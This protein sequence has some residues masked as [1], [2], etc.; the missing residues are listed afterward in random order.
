VSGSPGYVFSAESRALFR[1]AVRADDATWARARGWALT[2]GLEALP[3]YFDTHPGMVAMA[4]RVIR[5]TLN[6]QEERPR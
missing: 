4:R 3:H 2:Q 1:A 6:T 5:A